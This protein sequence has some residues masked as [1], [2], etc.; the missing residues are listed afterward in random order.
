MKMG[1]RYFEDIKNEKKYNQIIPTEEK[2]S[3]CD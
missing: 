3:S 1:Q 2:D